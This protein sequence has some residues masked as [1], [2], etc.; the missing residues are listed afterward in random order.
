M[1]FKPNPLALAAAL[2]AALSATLGGG[3]AHGAAVTDGSMGA[4][5]SL[6]G[7]FVVPQTLGQLRGN[8]L[9]HS[10]NSF[11]IARGEAAT[12]TTT[13]AGLQHVIARITGGQASTLDGALSLQA[14]AGA[15]PDFWLLNPN[16]VLVGAGASFDLPAGLHLSTAPQLRFAD[17]T[18]WTTQGSQPST[19]TVAAPE[20]FGFLPA[21]PAAALHWQGAAA[22]LQP[23]QTLQLAAGDIQLDGGLLLA[24]A[25]T[26][27]VQALGALTLSNGALLAAT[28][29]AL[30]SAGR[31]DIDAASLVIHGAEGLRTGLVAQTNLLADGRSS[32][33]RI[34]LTGALQMGPGA[35]ISSESL[36]LDGGGDIQL[37]AASLAMDGRGQR[38]T[39]G[40][41]NYGVGA[42]PAITLDLAGAATLDTADITSSASGGGAA[43]A[44]R[45]Q[46]GALNIDGRHAPSIGIQS[47]GEGSAAGALQL[48]VAG[49]LTLLNGARL[50]SSSDAADTAPAPLQVSAR[51]VQLQGN[52]SAT[53]IGSLGTGSAD[54][55]ALDLQASESVRLDAGGQISA[56]TLGSGRAGAVQLR[57]PQVDVAG[58][59]GSG[60][61]TGIYS[62]GLLPQAGRTGGVTVDAG[63]LQLSGSARISSGSYGGDGAG[64]VTVRADALTLD[65]RGAVAGIDAYAY[66]RGDAGG[67]TVQVKDLLSLRDGG[68]IIAGTAA[69]GDPGRIDIQ[70]GTLRLDGRGGH[71]LYTGIGGDSLVG[72]AGAAVSVQATRVEIFEG[73]AI[74][75]STASA[76]PAGAVTVVAD[77]IRIDGGGNANTATGISADT[78]AAG[79]GGNVLIRAK[80]LQVVDEGSISVSTIG[81]GDAGTL[82]VEADA[83]TLAR[84]GGIYSVAAASGSAGQI[85][86]QVSGTMA[87]Q[88]GGF[89]V[90][91]TG[92]QGAAGRIG[93][94]A[95]T[96]E[97]QGHDANGQRSRV[98]SRATTSS[99]GR[100][101]SIDIDVAGRFMLGSDALLST[102]NDAAVPTAAGSD[103]AHIRVTAAH[104]QLSGADI[105]A[106]ASDRAD[107]GA[108]RLQSAGTLVLSDSRLATSA[109]QGAGGPIDVQAAGVVLLRNS[110]VT[111]SVDS[112]QGGNGGDIRIAA[113]GLALAS[114]FVQANTAAV[115]GSGGTVAIDVPVL[116]PDGNNV[117]VGGDRIVDFRPG[118]PGFNVI[119]AAAP[120]G[121]SGRLTVTQ[122]ELN[123]AG[124]LAALSTARIDFGALGQDV[125][126]IGD[127]SSFT[128]L[129]R[130][131]L[132]PLASDPLRPPAPRR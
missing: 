79:H 91:N 19:L 69:S 23:G 96:F 110:S 101:G 97:A 2:A 34:T 21:T 10:F 63:Q 20:Q 112:N 8:N 26:V 70:A 125:C 62:T 111:T 93:I 85:E 131:A 4:V 48:Q 88:D 56:A 16:G 47:L 123:L 106:A 46:A 108:I 115:Q 41:S 67:V 118:T 51:S 114:G 132:P 107:A 24:P 45:L 128:P 84:S 89:V 116:L 127:D 15:R 130:G 35:E 40:S 6:S 87:L 73:A 52:G 36:A 55:A 31:V 50:W 43:G 122:P 98:A 53:V 9:F 29:P 30:D 33:I 27:R 129:G 22:V 74:S 121:L 14:G 64:P 105:T 124:G 90:A 39:I 103:A 49:P 68:S 102:A 18:V 109:H 82:R 80:D 7:Q 95:G 17:G 12:F 119:Q 92:G 13:S 75:S 38:S 37:R 32:G 57:S 58:G 25:G 120:N 66:G 11:S 83:L 77:S 117:Y 60:P 65:G 59:D 86:L 1:S 28:A 42:G 71:A 113:A 81:S 54:S 104:L 72:S 126:R 78:G 61:V 99:G 100:A 44:I 94:R 5:Q 3:L 76:R